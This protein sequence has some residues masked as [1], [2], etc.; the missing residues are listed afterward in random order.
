MSSRS[1]QTKIHIKCECKISNPVEMAQAHSDFVD[2]MMLLKLNENKMMRQRGFKYC[3][4]PSYSSGFGPFSGNG[5][6]A[7]QG[8]D[9]QLQASPNSRLDFSCVYFKEQKA[10]D[11]TLVLYLGEPDSL[12]KAGK[13]EAAPFEE[14]IKYSM[15]SYGGNLYSKYIIITQNDMTSQAKTGLKDY[16]ID[17]KF[18]VDNDFMEDIFNKAFNPI[19]Y[20]V[21][22]PG[23]EN[24]FEEEEEIKVSMLPQISVNDAY[25]QKLGLDIGSI[26]VTEVLIPGG[27]LGTRVDYRIVVV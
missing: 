27:N 22:L 9:F 24:V 1:K 14:A 3:M 26:I 8:M 13:K 20:K 10:E 19:S 15:D 7:Y 12:K 11:G 23:N 4:F 21:Y 5:A 17:L 16:D 2:K 25:I 6:V 18:F